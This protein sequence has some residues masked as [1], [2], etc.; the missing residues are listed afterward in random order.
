MISDYGRAKTNIQR[1]LHDY[2]KNSGLRSLVIGVSGGI[3][4][5]V[6]CA[7]A[8]PVCDALDVRLIGRSI[9]IETNQ[10]DEISRARSIGNL[11]CHD[12]EEVD[13][14]DAYKSLYP[15]LMEDDFNAKDSTDLTDAYA[16]SRKIRKGNIKARMR[17]LYLYDLAQYNR[18]M[19][20]STD[21]YTELLC[22]FWTLHGDVGDYGM[23]QGLWKSEVYAMTEYII[24]HGKLTD[25][26]EDALQLCIFATPTDGLGITN[27]DLDQLG[28]SSYGQVDTILRQYLS[29]NTSLENNPV[30]MRYNRTHFK[31]EN[32][33]NIPR[34]VI[35]G[36]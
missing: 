7:L 24:N 5:A 3:D 1:E 31:R 20:L 18:G 23:I 27:S 4:S 32:P 6:C 34:N 2:L 15:S 35:V 17:M 33:F 30:I 9:T 21:N 26:Q 11:F 36:I 8:R 25:E 29:G 14:T 22:G 19:V 10:Q 13:L 16:L 12:F 28:V